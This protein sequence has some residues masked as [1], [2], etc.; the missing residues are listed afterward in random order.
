MKVNLGQ[1]VTHLDLFDLNPDEGENYQLSHTPRE[2]TNTPIDA[3]MSVN[4]GHNIHNQNPF[5]A[6]QLNA[7]QELRRQRNGPSGRRSNS[8]GGDEVDTIN[9]VTDSKIGTQVSR[10]KSNLVST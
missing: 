8:N 3:V 7:A 2:T 1:W 4:Q 9:I 5:S 6:A 10:A